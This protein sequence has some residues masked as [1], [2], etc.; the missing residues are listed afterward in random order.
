[1]KT[2][3]ILAKMELIGLTKEGK[4]IS[5]NQFKKIADPHQ[6]GNR[7]NK[8]YIVYCGLPKENLFGFYPP[9]TT[10]KESLEIAYQY[11]LSIFEDQDINEFAYGNIKWG[12]TGYPISYRKLG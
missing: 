2:D 12:D 7:G 3:E 6:Y 4:A 1:M 9:R 5:F 10:K 11:Y 8:I